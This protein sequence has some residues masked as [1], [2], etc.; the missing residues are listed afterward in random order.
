MVIA[1]L[2]Q[3]HTAAEAGRAA[4]VSESTVVRRLREPRF[5]RE[6]QA[7]RA[8]A[9]GRAVN[10]LVEATMAAAIT[11]RD[12]AAHATQE[13]VQLAAATRVLDLAFKGIE[14]LDVTDRLEALEAALDEAGV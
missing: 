1:A 4:G 14:V 6:L 12:L 11:L 5:Q 9:L 2:L 3:G 7:A 13:H 8:R 10:V